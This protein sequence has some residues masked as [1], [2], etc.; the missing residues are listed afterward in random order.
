ML[1]NNNPVVTDQITFTKNPVIVDTVL[2]MKLKNG[3]IKPAIDILVAP[4]EL[5]YLFVIEH[6]PKSYKKID[7][8]FD[9][10]RFFSYYWACCCNVFFHSINTINIKR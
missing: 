7:L 10:L 6:G 4:L 3:S 8:M 9:R 5:C 1:G 2:F